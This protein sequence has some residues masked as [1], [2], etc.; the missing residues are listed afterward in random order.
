MSCD[1][2]FDRSQRYERYQ[3]YGRYGRSE[4]Y[5]RSERTALPTY[6]HALRPYKQALRTYKH[7]QT[8]LPCS[9][10]IQTLPNCPAVP[11]CPAALLPCCP[12]ALL[13]CPALPCGPLPC[14]HTKTTKLACLALPTLNCPA[15][16]LPCSGRTD[17]HADSS[18]F[19]NKHALW[20]HKQAL[21][22]H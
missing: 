7:H 8:A 17:Q 2:A 4:R 21:R 5:E 3:R 18:T 1:L 9:A 12:A 6:K 20:T 19:T 11:C 16:L 10:D 15:A 14:G 22:T 13:P